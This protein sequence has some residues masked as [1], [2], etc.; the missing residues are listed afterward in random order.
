MEK[1]NAY[2]IPP[3]K[4]L[5]PQHLGESASI[6]LQSHVLEQLAV[7]AV[8][9]LAAGDELALAAC[10][11]AVVDAEGHLHGGVVDLHKGQGL[12]VGGVAQGVADGHIGDAAE[13]DDIAG[14][15]A[16]CGLTA[17]GLEVVQLG[18]AALDGNIGVVPVAHR[19]VLAHLGHAVLDAADADAAHKVVVVHAGAQHLEGLLRVT[20]GALDVLQDGLKQRLEVDTGLLPAVAGGTGAAGAEHHG[21]VQLLIWV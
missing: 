16:L 20:L 13:C 1:Q 3:G 14:A 10:E 18:D 17:V 21:A 9:D 5:L 4:Y 7:Q 12:H 19:H 6:H 8:A 15:G 11:G 2:D